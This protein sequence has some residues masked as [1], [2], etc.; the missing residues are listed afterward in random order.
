MK[1][2][3]LPALKAKPESLNSKNRTLDAIISTGQ[4]DRDGEIIEPSA[5]KARI[6]TFM[7]NPIVLW[8]HDAMSPPIGK[9]TERRFRGEGYQGE[10]CLR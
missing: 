9:V 6:D 3:K 8:M 1:E 5:F 10:L 7:E 4:V 2:L